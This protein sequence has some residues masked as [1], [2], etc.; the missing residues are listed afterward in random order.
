MKILLDTSIV[1]RLSE[2]DALENQRAKLATATLP[3]LGFECC[4]IP[5]IVYEYWSVATRSAAQNGLGLS[6]EETARDVS[7]YLLA[8]ALLRDERTVFERWHQLVIQHDVRGKSVHDARIVAAMQRHGISHL[9]TL[10]S[11]DFLRYRDITVVTPA[12]VL[13]RAT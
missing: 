1:V 2:R 8:F 7:Q 9:L 5:Q 11:A 13:A 3:E 4:I 10:N 6:P 12:E